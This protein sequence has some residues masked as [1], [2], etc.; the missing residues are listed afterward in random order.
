MADIVLGALG[1]AFELG[2]AAP[3][4]RQFRYLCCF[5]SNVQ[6]LNDEAKKLEDERAGLEMEVTTAKYNAQ[7]VDP[8]VD[9]WLKKV[10]EI[11]QKM[12]ALETKITSIQGG[13]CLYVKSR[14]SISKRAIKTTEA[15]K[16]MLEDRCKISIISHPRSPPTSLVPDILERPT[17]DFESRK[18]IEEDIMAI[19]RDEKVKIMGICGMGGIGKTTL[20]KKVMSRVRKDKL[21]DK[22][23]MAVVS[24]HVDKEKI[25]EEIADNLGLEL[26]EKSLSS[27]AKILCSRLMN[28]ER[29]LIV[30]DDV[31]E[32][33]KLEE[34]GIPD[35]DG[36]SILL[37]SRDRD[38]LAR[39]DAKPIL[40]METLTEEEA[41]SFFKE[42]IRFC[43]N[44]QNRLSN[45]TQEIAMECKGLP[46]ALAS[47]AGALKDKKDDISI[48]NDAL[49]QLKSSNPEDLSEVL[50]N[51]YT[52]L[53]LSYDYLSSQNARFIFLLCCL[54]P[55]DFSIPLED[56]AAYALGLRMFDGT[57]KLEKVRNRIYAL[58]DMLKSRFLLLEGKDER[59]VRMH[60]VVRDV[61]I[62]ITSNEKQLIKC[63]DTSIWISPFLGE[64][65]ELSKGLTFPN[66]R[67]L[68]VDE[69]AP[70][71]LQSSG[72]HFE[73]MNEL[74]VLSIMA[75]SLRSLPDTTRC[76]KNLQ[77]LILQRCSLKTLCFVGE[78]E[79]L[80]ILICRHCDKVEELPSETARLKRLKLLEI[81]DCEAVKK[82]GPGVISSLDKLEELKFVKSFDKWEADD[83]KENENVGLHEL[84]CL[85]NLTSLDIQVKD[86][87][88]AAQQISL[89]RKIE[90]YHITVGDRVSD[91]GYP[92]W[93][94]MNLYLRNEIIL[95]NWI[96][97]YVANAE[98]LVLKGDGSN[99]VDLGV[100][101]KNIRILDFG[102]CTTASSASSLVRG[103]GA[104]IVFPLLEI[105]RLMCLFFLEEIWDING[106]ISEVSSS[107]SSNYS[108]KNLKELRLRDLRSLKRL[109][110]TSPNV[111]SLYTNLSSIVVD[112]CPRLLNLSPLS[113]SK[114][115]FPQLQSICIKSCDMMEHV[116]S[117]NEE[118]NEDGSRLITIKFPKLESLELRY[119]PNLR[120]IC[121]G[122]ESIECPLLT[123]IDIKGCPQLN[124]D[125]SHS[126]PLIRKEKVSFENLKELPLTA[127]AKMM[128]IFSPQLEH[129][130]IANFD[131][132]KSL[133][134][135][136][137]AQGLDSLKILRINY[138]TKMVKVIEEDEEERLHEINLI[139]PHLEKLFLDG[140][141]KLKTF[142]HWSR[143]LELPKLVRVFINGCSEM[144]SFNL[145]S[146]TTPNLKSLEQLQIWDCDKM[147]RVFSWDEDESRLLT[148]KF[149]KL[150]SLELR[151]L[152]N[153][154][155]ICQGIESIEC[156]LLTRIDIE[157]CPQLNGD[158]SH[159]LPLIRKEKVSFENLKELPL[160][161][162][163]KIMNIFSPQLEH[164]EIA[165]FDNIKSLFSFSIAQGLD[166]L[167]IL[168]IVGCK[169]MV[170]VIEEDEEERLHEIN[171]IFP[172]LEELYLEGLPKL[173][174]F[175]HWRRGLEL[176]KLVEV[177]INGCSEMT[178]FNLGSLTTPNLK[179]LEQLRI[180]DCT[181][182]EQVFLW[183]EQENGKEIIGQSSHDHHHIT[184][185][186]LKFL[187]LSNLPGL[188]NFSKGIDSITLP[189]LTVMVMSRCPNLEGVVS[190][191]TSSSGDINN[192]VVG[193]LKE[194]TIYWNQFPIDNFTRLEELTIEGFDKISFLFSNSIAG[195]LINL[196]KLTINC[197]NNLVKV[198]EEEI[199]ES[200][201][202]SLLFPHLE[203]LSLH[204]LPKLKIFCEWRC[205]LELPSLEKMSIYHCREMERFSLGSLSA[206]NLN[207]ISREFVVI[208]ITGN[209]ND[210]LQQRFVILL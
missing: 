163:A 140:L 195:I 30:L 60:D 92:F 96:Q 50:K 35:K 70:E 40:E 127:N 13:G 21:F 173:K 150:E 8:K 126:L 19:L 28:E 72:I 97:E 121:Q 184:F 104:T 22:S 193:K 10:N 105:M 183:S 69:S 128:N 98:C 146:L 99:G 4:K 43:A 118:E 210:V 188:T 204:E 20:A 14:Y 39:M 41:L 1:L 36:C 164:L 67:L 182:M 16:Q 91:Y 53:K 170:K 209:L 137:I 117:W 110:K 129:L 61:A 106:P 37:T 32:C 208:T 79:N 29:I 15:M 107:S 149:P 142:C 198:I 81:S 206:P 185:P 186:R 165:N 136:S 51:V 161:A 100:A 130:E 134:S 205:A 119:L 52:P 157:G 7:K 169:K 139:F 76:L 148:I 151:N 125:D 9:S 155:V 64:R 44:D 31:W 47:V 171:L 93:K 57:W 194:Q 191:T 168:R 63:G 147:E 5:N 38:V 85:P 75:P 135:L 55:E 111:V 201:E 89:P 160:T 156:P 176:P 78:L 181:M 24:E 113:T 71:E 2:I 27:R 65:I 84:E 94:I 12:N 123:R 88:L 158:D 25:Q 190:A 192:K 179:S 77:T 18:E 23:V 68:M 82:I 133:F 174:T 73:G 197:C 115:C 112:H 122:I 141:P 49:Q 144:T 17:S 177:F 62:F 58:V 103:C 166:S 207:N 87:N 114:D 202:T 34:L 26:K 124:G 11:Q 167:K 83:E 116:F 199:D 162:N 131:N 108:F 80:E 33:L 66:L 172:H 159:S 178:S 54:F 175:C 109:W 45:L 6:S 3:I 59:Y 187:G 46:L 143:G 196:K 95:G 132:I 86:Y 48:W 180:R 189:L 90:K 200:H 138:C 153:L 102:Y 42:K 145:G 152:P 154:R 101:Q 56:L 74:N 203:E 120:V